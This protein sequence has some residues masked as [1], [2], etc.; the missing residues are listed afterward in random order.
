[1]EVFDCSRVENVR[2]LC[3]TFLGFFDS[4]VDVERRYFELF[5]TMLGQCRYEC[6]SC[7]RRTLVEL[8]RSLLVLFW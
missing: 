8:V 4:S 3:L 7:M 1:V 2:A 5:M 6:R